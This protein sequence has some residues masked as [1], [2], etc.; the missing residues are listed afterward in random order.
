MS[1]TDFNLAEYV[2]DV[3]CQSCGRRTIDCEPMFWCDRCQ[4]WVCRGCRIG[5]MKIETPDG[6]P[7]LWVEPWEG[8]G[9]WFVERPAWQRHANSV[10]TED[11]F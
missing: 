1:V 6:H 2:R 9:G 5:H 10:A 3:L 11:L 8:E 7:G 4:V